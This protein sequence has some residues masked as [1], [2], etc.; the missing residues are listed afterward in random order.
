MKNIDIDKYLNEVSIIKNYF[1]KLK[2]DEFVESYYV[3]DGIWSRL[4]LYFDISKY[5]IPPVD[6]SKLFISPEDLPVGIPPE[7]KP[8]MDKIKRDVSWMTT[9]TTNGSRYAIGVIYGRKENI[10]WSFQQ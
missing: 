8:Q 4:N 10:I 2:I 7:F 5:P 9:I 6:P 1:K 3:E